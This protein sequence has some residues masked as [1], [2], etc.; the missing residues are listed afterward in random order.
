MSTLRSCVRLLVLLIFQGE[1]SEAEA[2][3][4]RL[5]QLVANAEN[6]KRVFRAAADYCATAEQTRIL[7]K[8]RRA[9]AQIQRVLEK[10]VVLSCPFCLWTCE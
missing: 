1:R 8:T 5:L 6:R 9:I 3:L 4:N 2:E 7:H 10:P